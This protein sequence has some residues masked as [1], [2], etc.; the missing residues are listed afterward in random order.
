MATNNKE[1]KKGNVA[2]GLFWSF[3]E[4]ITAQLVSLIITIV[5]ARL[6]DPDH[7]AVVAIVSII[8]TI[9]NAFVTGGF[10]NSL[11]QK[12][13]ADELDFS[14]MLIFSL[15]L[16]LLFYVVL[17]VGA[18]FIAEFY[19]MEELTAIIRVMGIRI[20]VAA[21]NSI[22]HAYVSKQMA[23]R[24]F[25]ISTSFGT[26]ISGIV[27]ILMAYLG[28]GAWAL[29]W[30]YLTN[31][32]IDTIV[33][34]FTCG[35]KPSFRFS[36]IRVKSLFSYGW[37]LL[38][39]EVLST[40]YSE[41]RGM[42]LSKGFEATELSYYNQGRKYPALFNN[43]IE[44]SVN[45]VLFQ[46]LSDEQEDLPKVKEITSITVSISSFV[47][48][49]LFM[50]LMGCANSLVS[51]LLTDKWLPCVEYLRIACLIYMIT[52]LIS[53]LT[54]TIKSQGSSGAFLLVT[55]LRYAVGIILIIISL[56]VFN[57]PHVVVF[58]GFV[59]MVIMWL[60]SLRINKKLIGYGFLEQIKDFG[61]PLLNS[62]IMF[63]LLMLIESLR[64][65]SW[66]TL[67]IQI[68]VGFSSYIGLS[69]LLNRKVSLR[70]WNFIEGKIKFKKK[71]IQ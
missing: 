50:G 57:E 23:F 30:Q 55:V 18:P 47:L 22:Q 3:G 71:S 40:V 51:I 29:V 54:R 56:I 28:F 65:S 32:T 15:L 46:K 35:W 8:I 44:A 31:V 13:D 62:T 21:I 42:V 33:L 17:F 25:F 11:I 9:A 69:F 52:P 68:I 48:F 6:L 27:G 49:P 16:S 4:R 41:I 34:Q 64:M 66:K 5:L 14:S 37:K 24:K 43:N 59:A 19:K 53:S 39:A 1:K 67:I 2:S 38:V 12:K 36:F 10:G 20:I 63:V 70:V 58:S 26:V 60:L 7:Y 45:K 61:R